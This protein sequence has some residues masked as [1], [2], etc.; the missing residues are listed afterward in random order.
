[1]HVPV[2]IRALEKV[3]HSGKENLIS[4][5]PDSLQFCLMISLHEFWFCEP[6]REV[7]LSHPDESLIFKRYAGFPKE[8][9][10]DIKKEGA[11]NSFQMNRR[12]WLSGE[13][14]VRDFSEG[15]KIELLTGYGYKWED[16]KGDADRNMIIAE[17]YFEMN[18]LDF[19]ND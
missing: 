4:T 7:L 10:K 13:I 1:M 17:T 15:E 11:A 19:K 18:P 2:T 5:D 3:K 6:D 16:F 8:F 14:D 9:I 12:L